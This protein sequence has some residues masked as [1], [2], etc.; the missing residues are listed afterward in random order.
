M[1]RLAAYLGPPLRLDRLLTEPAHSL[2]EQS[3]AP[4]EMMEARLNAD[5]YGFGWFDSEGRPLRYRYT[6]PIW[7]DPNL[8]D[9]GRA[10]VSPTW[11]AVVRSATTNIPVSLVNTMPYVDDRYQF[12]H[13]GYINHFSR[14]L[15]SCLRR[16]LNP[17]FEDAIEGN[18]DSE[19]LFVLFRQI[20]WEEGYQDPAD[21]LLEMVVRLRRWLKQE[22]AL[23]NL[24]IARPG[25]VWVMRCA[26]NGNCPSLYYTLNPP[27]Y[28]G[29][30]L[31]ASEPLSDE[32]DWTEVPPQ[33]LLVFDDGGSEPRHIEL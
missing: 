14:T 21:A 25:R 11:V 2:V 3:W 16:E 7:T 32:A 13:N 17:E 12:L 22:R 26:I 28:P 9:M 31:I 29:A 23:L 6:M 18:T 24:M 15:R 33:S 10:L 19:H 20:M 30:A 27:P 8:D 4:R 5:G 1:C